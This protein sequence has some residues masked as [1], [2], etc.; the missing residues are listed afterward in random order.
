MEPSFK[1]KYTNHSDDDSS[2]EED[3]DNLHR[4][5]DTENIGNQGFSE[6]DNS[7]ESDDESTTLAVIEDNVADFE[8][9]EE[10]HQTT[11]T[12]ENYKRLGCFV[13]TLQ[14]VVNSSVL[15]SNS[16]IK[17]ARQIVK[18]CNKSYKMTEKLVKKAGKKL[19]NDVPTRWNSTFLMFNRLLDVKSHL[20]EILE[21]Q[22]WDS[23]TSSKLQVIQKLSDPFHHHTNITCAEDSTT[24]AM[25]IPVL[26]E[27]E[28]HLK[29]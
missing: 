13:H 9:V 4:Q 27:L 22:E 28:L 23:L 21:E 14:L 7:D 20:V 16:A 1:P 25:V 15:S 8:M 11:F 12:S 19:I 6:S 3:F 26:K 5:E 2:S 24:I 17:K 10:I 18:R 29:K